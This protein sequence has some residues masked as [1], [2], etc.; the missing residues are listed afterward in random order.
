VNRRQQILWPVAT[1]VAAIGGCGGDPD[2]GDRVD[3]SGIYRTSH[4]TDNGMGCAM[5]GATVTDPTHF[6]IQRESLLGVPVYSYE[7]CDGPTEAECG[8]GSS[9]LGVPFS[10]PIPGGYRG[11]V[12]YSFGSAPDCTLGHNEGTAVLQDDGS[13]RIEVREHEEA[14]EMVSEDDCGSDAAESR[15]GSLP[16]T[17]FQ[18]LVGVPVDAT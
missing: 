9:A 16:C 14:L 3:I 18:V 7:G 6:R 2:G 17:T 5:E 15:A 10:E 11:E 8:T 13:L 1:V 4:H 12:F